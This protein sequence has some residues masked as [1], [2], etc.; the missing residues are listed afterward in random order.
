MAT[1]A[2]IGTSSEC[3]SSIAVPSPPTL[4]S[5]HTRCEASWNARFTFADCWNE[6]FLEA[7]T[8]KQSG[9][10]HCCKNTSYWTSLRINCWNPAVCKIKTW[11]F[12][13]L[14]KRAISLHLLWAACATNEFPS[15]RSVIAELFICATKRLPNCNSSR[16]LKTIVIVKFQLI[17]LYRKMK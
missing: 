16:Y 7:I 10:V 17:Q 13:Q 11:T 9:N 5:A 4:I 6:Y 8:T 15:N 1:T 3:D 12:L 14:G 2:W